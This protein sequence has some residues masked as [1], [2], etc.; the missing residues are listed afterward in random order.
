M[1]TR[2]STWPWVSVTQPVTS[3]AVAGVCAISRIAIMKAAQRIG[4]KV[5]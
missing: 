5:F 3:P 4:V 2:G 1:V